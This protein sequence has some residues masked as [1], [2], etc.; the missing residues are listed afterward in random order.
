MELLNAAQVMAL[1][2][3]GENRARTIIRQLNQELADKGFMTIRGK[4]PKR[5]LEE[6]FYK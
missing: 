6:R 1:L 4:V 5:Y 2:H 3:V